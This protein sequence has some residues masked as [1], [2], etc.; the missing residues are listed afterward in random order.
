LAGEDQHVHATLGVCSVSQEN[1]T[2]FSMSHADGLLDEATGKQMFPSKPTTIP[3]LWKSV[4]EIG[5]WC[6]MLAYVENSQDNR[7]LWDRAMDAIS[8]MGD[9]TT[10][11][12]E[13]IRM[14]HEA[15]NSIGIA[16]TATQGI[17]CPLA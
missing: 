13:K 3:A 15:G 5:V 11:V 17:M 12:T 10:P 6:L 16:R 9:E 1:V 4:Q 8:G 7:T 2:Y 14:W